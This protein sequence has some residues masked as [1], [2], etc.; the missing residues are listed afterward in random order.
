MFVFPSSGDVL[1]SSVFESGAREFIF[2][3]CGRVGEESAGT[4]DAFAKDATRDPID[5][6][7]KH[8]DKTVG[9]SLP[10]T[11]KSH[12]TRL[13]PREQK[14]A[15]IYSG[16]ARFPQPKFRP[17]HPT[18]TGSSAR[19]KAKILTIPVLVLMDSPPVS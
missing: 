19:N 10:T 2:R 7:R 13:P 15:F 4:R 6:A 5:S 1:P 11:A 18:D 14:T 9:A 3:P 8:R 12:A 17:R 16:R